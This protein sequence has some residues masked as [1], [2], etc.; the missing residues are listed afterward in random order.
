MRWCRD[1]QGLNPVHIAAMKGH[2]EM[3]EE[4]LREDPLPAMERV[5][6]GQTV[7]HLCVKHR[8]LGALKLLVEKLGDLVYAKDDDGET[9]LHWAARS[10][11]VK[12]IKY[13]VGINKI[14][15]KSMNSMG[16]T[17]VELVEESCDEEMTKAMVSIMPPLAWSWSN[18]AM[19]EMLSKKREQ[20]TMVVMAL[21]ATMAFQAA[22]SPPGGVW[23]EDTSSHR[24]GE[25]VMATT[26]PKIYRHLIRANTTAFVS[27][28]LTIFMVAVPQSFGKGILLNLSPYAVWVSLAAIAVTYGGSVLVVVPNTQTRSLTGIIYV[29]VAVSLGLSGIRF[30]RDVFIT[31]C[32]KLFGYNW[33]KDTLTRIRRLWNMV[34]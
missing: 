4:L 25:A 7:L 23:Q 5:H 19:L 31:C 24:A 18:P 27:S 21:I 32:V 6:R 29:V 17:A 26:H 3:L 14:E 33:V 30:L 28:L 10:K 34:L 20:Q 12:V 13:L 22:V 11:Q 2:V 9:L 15:K 8:Q 1:D 16:R